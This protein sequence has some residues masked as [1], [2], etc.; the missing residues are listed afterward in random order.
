MKLHR[1]A[2]PLAVFALS[3]G[4]FS[5]ARSRLVSLSAS[6]PAQAYLLTGDEPSYMLLA[7]SLVTDGDFNLYNNRVNKDGRF[8]GM[9]RCDEHGA[10]KDWGKKEIYSIHTP[11][12]AVLIAP[13]YALG[14]HG[15]LA[16][17]T[18]A[19]L[20]MNLIAALLAVN[21]YLFC[22][23]IIG[24]GET[25]Y[26]RTGKS[27]AALACT[28][29]VVFTPPVIFYSNLIYP[30]LPAAL[31]ILYTFRHVILSAPSATSFGSCSANRRAGEPE[32]RRMNAIRNGVRAYGRTGAFEALESPARPFAVSP[33]HLLSSLA[34]A[35]LP[36]LSFRFFLPALILL[37]LL[38][39]SSQRLS[40]T[41]RYA[42][43][44][45]L[46]LFTVSLIFFFY[47]QYL[48]FRTLN[49]AAGYVYQDFARRGF[50]SKGMLDGVFGLL[51]DEGHGI[52]TWSPVYMLSLTG[53]LIL[54]R[55][56]RRLGLWLSLLLLAIYLP[57]AHF[58]FWWGGF[59]PPP[60]YLVVP[61]PLLG[62][63]L[64]Y[65][66]SRDP[67][68][69]F[70]S[71][72]GLLLAASLLFGYVGC[73]HPGLLY[74]HRHIVPNY[75]PRLMTRLFPSFFHK[76]ASTWPLAAVWGVVI[77]MIN[78][79]FFLTWNKENSR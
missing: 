68:T 8:F 17:R 79:Y 67:R 69:S 21:V 50:F 9:E 51:L 64:C 65:A 62:A 4:I 33:S 2:I 72:C 37:W 3:L 18:T 60:R 53:L 74:K 7:H 52:L 44:P 19:C 54:I 57:G 48:A 42:G 40:P 35:A 61:A 29:A 46:F 30:E 27:W 23:E 63:L 1:T 78:G 32:N 15:P 47:Y 26:P 55:E 56:R 45:Y 14:L 34:I 24:E 41:R 58:I 77:V 36:W 59:A 25:A 20:F 39:R 12:L 49:P 38:I 22:S 16:P 5:L 11:G 75:H 10:R 6:G 70:I 76:R 31:L 43:T 13:A 28:A 71:L 66:L 73:R